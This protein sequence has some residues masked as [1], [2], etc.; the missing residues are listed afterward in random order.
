MGIFN[1]KKY[2]S[3]LYVCSLLALEGSSSFKVVQPLAEFVFFVFWGKKS[4][5]IH[6]V[7]VVYLR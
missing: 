7:V 6:F 5:V 4:L 1:G 2:C 3:L